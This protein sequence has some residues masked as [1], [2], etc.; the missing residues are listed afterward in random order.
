MKQIKIG[1]KTTLLFILVGTIGII[2]ISIS[3]IVL[4][5]RT[6]NYICLFYI[7]SENNQHFNWLILCVNGI[8]NISMF[9]TSMLIVHYIATRKRL[10]QQN[11][12]RNERRLLYTT[13]LKCASNTL[14]GI[15]IIVLQV[16][17]GYTKVNRYAIYFA[18]IA[19]IF[20]SIFNPF[21]TTFTSRLFIE[22][23]TV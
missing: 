6:H 14:C 1:L 2:A 4:Y 7:E 15:T 21:I 17:T 10:N 13:I 22:K 19:M 5:D 3:N 12:S 9:G 23:V 16:L 8:N 20:N 11:M 18:I